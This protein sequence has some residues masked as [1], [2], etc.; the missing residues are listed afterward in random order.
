[1]TGLGIYGMQNGD[2]RLILYPLD[3]DGNVCGTDKGDIDMTNYPYLYYVNDYSGG[4]C[5]KECPKLEQLA[6]PYTL[7][8][9]DGLFHV[10]GSFVT[11]KDID[12]ADYST[13]NNTLDCTESLCYPDGNPESSYNS[14]GVMQ[15]NG[16]AYYA[17]DTY[18]VFWR[19]VFTDEGTEKLNPIVNPNGDKFKE[20]VIDMATQ[21]E[22]IKQGYDVWH[23][24]FGDM[25]TSRFFILGLGFGAPIVSLL[26]DGQRR[27]I[28]SYEWHTFYLHFVMCHVLKYGSLNAR[29]LRSWDSST[30]SC[31]EFPEYSP[32]WSGSPS[33]QQSASSSP[34]LGTREIRQTSGKLPIRPPTPNRKSISQRTRPTR[35]T[36]WV[37]SSFWFSCS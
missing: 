19:C 23:N 18:Q 22:N 35:S 9:Y 12:M 31:Y 17:L 27:C 29:T 1:M 10:N 34:A 30:H 26:E 4:V 11:E 20:D 24:L 6:D 3:Y 21:N 15:G 25:W 7:V 33:S 37:D 13:S 36:P 28:S 2:Y 14:F 16:F 8:T 5:V 32:S